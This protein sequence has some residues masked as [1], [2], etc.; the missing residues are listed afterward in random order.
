VNLKKKA[1]EDELA[2]VDKDID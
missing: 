2:R 1:M